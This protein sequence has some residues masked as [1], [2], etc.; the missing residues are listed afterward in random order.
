MCHVLR[1]PLPQP[2]LSNRTPYLPEL[3]LA[4][5]ASLQTV[6]GKC[7]SDVGY[8]WDDFRTFPSSIPSSSFHTLL[9]SLRRR[10]F[11]HFL[12]LM[13]WGVCV[14]ACACVWCFNGGL[15]FPSS[16][17]AQSS[18][19]HRMNSAPGSLAFSPCFLGLHSAPH[20][21]Q[22]FHRIP[23]TPNFTPTQCWCD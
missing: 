10:C 17:L 3:L 2:V 18:L 20:P 1:P 7:C 15:C 16:S 11:I 14:C 23:L 13:D 8:T 9:R 5:G 4:V 12:S 22:P 19:F 6:I 21:K